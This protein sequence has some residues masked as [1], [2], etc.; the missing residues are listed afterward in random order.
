MKTIMIIS[1]ICSMILSIAFFAPSSSA[2]KYP[3]AP[4]IIKGKIINWQTKK[5]VP[6]ATVIAFLNGAGYSVNNGFGFQ[7]YDYP[8]FAKS[9][10]SGEFSAKT[11]LYSLK[12]NDTPKQIELIIFCEGYRTEKFFYSRKD[13]SIAQNVDGCEDGWGIIDNIIVELFES[14]E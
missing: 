9:N 10:N 8:N 1:F 7:K 4:F 2:D 14:K 13:F 12:K 6:N 5:P 3:N 11:Q